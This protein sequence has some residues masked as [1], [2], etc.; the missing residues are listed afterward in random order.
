MDGWTVLSRGFLG[1]GT[2]DMPGVKNAKVFMWGV[3]EVRRIWK[4]E[5]PHV[6]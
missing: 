4:K 1:G 2:R 5:N 6:E 3:R